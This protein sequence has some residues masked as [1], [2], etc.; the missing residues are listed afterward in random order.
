[1]SGISGGTNPPCLEFRHAD[2]AKQRRADKPVEIAFVDQGLAGEE[3]ISQAA[4]K[5]VRL[6][7]VKLEEAKRRFV[8]LPS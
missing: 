2:L 6:V 8:L 7:I 3:S 4:A 1:M 5:R